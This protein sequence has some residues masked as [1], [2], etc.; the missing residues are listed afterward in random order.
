MADLLERRQIRDQFV[1]KP[2]GVRVTRVSGGAEAAPNGCD[3][4]RVRQMIAAESDWAPTACRALGILNWRALHR[5]CGICGGEMEEYDDVMARQ[6][7]HCHHIEYPSASPAVIVR[8]D[9]D[10]KI[11]LARHAQ[12]SQQFYTCLA[13]Y[14]EV[15]ESAEAC[16]HREIKEETGLEVTD[17]R[18]AGSQHWPYPNQLML[19]FTARWQ[20]GELQLQ[21]EELSDA[22]WFDP[23]ELPDVPPAG[24]VAYQLI[25]GLL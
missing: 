17:V 4:V 14:V 24:S 12:R 25:H 6:C 16:V 8:V 5:F 7:R 1:L 13:G 18:Y 9:R 20:S 19:A 15:G 23:A 2:Q 21:K 3:W 22:Q 11:L 10:G